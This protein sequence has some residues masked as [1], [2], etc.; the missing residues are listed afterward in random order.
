[1][2]EIEAAARVL[3]GRVRRKQ[4]AI[5]TKRDYWRAMEKTATEN[6]IRDIEGALGVVDMIEYRCVPSARSHEIASLWWWSR[7]R[8]SMEHIV[9]M[10]TPEC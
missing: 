8:I 7:E 10:Q 9:I 5:K 3:Q 4:F 6:A 1:M 2:E